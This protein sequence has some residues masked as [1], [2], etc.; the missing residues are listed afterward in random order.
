M[1]KKGNRYV[2]VP[3]GMCRSIKELTSKEQIEYIGFYSKTIKDKEYLID[4]I[5][6][7]SKN[8]YA[9]I[10]D[11]SNDMYNKV[12]FSVFKEKYGQPTL[13]DYFDL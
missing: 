3:L 8:Y 5:R 13:F 1:K 6:T 4:I 2:N 9:D 10:T 7:S 12:E 11:V